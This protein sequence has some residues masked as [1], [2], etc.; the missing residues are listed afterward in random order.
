LPRNLARV[1]E[2][3]GGSPGRSRS[4]GDRLFGAAAEPSA[5]RAVRVRPEAPRSLRWAA[6]VVGIEAG[7][8]AFGALA[9]LYLTLTS[10]ADSVSRALAEVVVVF[11]GAAVLAACAVG[12]WRVA[13]WARGPVVVLQ[14][15]LAA[16][17]YT[18][19]FEADQPLI[20]VP[21]L[22]LVATEL[23]LLATPEAR[24]AYL[25]R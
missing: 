5:P 4:W 22:V 6:V 19:A 11:A 3:G 15:L 25:E 2:Q 14:L 9:L 8:I 17:A 13:G 12:L 7:A 18:T 23:Y 16:L 20:G 24:L 10:T 21:V 1:T